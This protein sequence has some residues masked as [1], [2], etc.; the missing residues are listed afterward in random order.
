MFLEKKIFYAALFALLTP[1]V[2]LPTQSSIVLPDSA[3]YTWP[4]NNHLTGQYANF[5]LGTQEITIGL[6]SH[7]TT[8]Q[9]DPAW[10]RVFYFTTDTIEEFSF[11]I[12]TAPNQ[13]E[14]FFDNDSSPTSTLSFGAT[15]SPG[16]IIYL[17]IILSKTSII[18]RAYDLEGGA[19]AAADS[20]SATH[21]Q[22]APNIALLTS[23]QKLKV[24]SDS[25][26]VMYPAFISTSPV[27]THPQISNA[28]NLNWY[29][30]GDG[31]HTAVTGRVR[32]YRSRPDEVYAHTTSVSS[33]TGPL[34]CTYLDAGEP[35][36]QSNWAYDITAGHP[37]TSAAPGGWTYFIQKSDTQYGFYY[38]P[39][40]NIWQPIGWPEATGAAMHKESIPWTYDP[41]LMRWNQS[42]QLE[43]WTYDATTKKWTG[44]HHTFVT[45]EWLY[46]T[47]S[48]NY[49]TKE[50]SNETTGETWT[51]RNECAWHLD[52]SDGDYFTVSLA[53]GLSMK[54]LLDAVWYSPW[55]SGRM[56]GSPNESVYQ[57]GDMT[58]YY[59][60][61]VPTGS[62]PFGTMAPWNSDLTE[63]RSTNTTEWLPVSGSG[64][65]RFPR[66][67]PP[68]VVVQH[69]EIISAYDAGEAQE[70]FNTTPLPSA[71]WTNNGRSNEFGLSI[72]Y[73]TDEG[74]APLKVTTTDP[75]TQLLSNL[76][77]NPVFTSLGDWQLIDSTNG[78]TWSFEDETGIWTN[79]TTGHQIQY[80]SPS[81]LCWH[82]A[83]SNIS[84]EYDENTQTWS[85]VIEQS[86]S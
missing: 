38:D 69:Q 19:L 65:K 46:N 5:P 30:I 84:W 42:S 14:F 50:W 21:I 26:N 29:A 40:T 24:Q 68:L 32:V 20:T 18:L 7:V 81:A 49:E 78:H 16:D 60:W 73:D 74:T 1:C 36:S 22:D 39:A 34:S 17:H 59:N 55:R 41:V 75:N 66:N 70:I 31:T 62:R 44:A 33:L 12:A 6:F 3:W 48:Y 47:W 86:A 85:Q 8:A 37:A 13:V 23:W 11:K 76:L 61:K 28:N 72:P 4:G 25:V 83:T 43:N 53:N 57:N 80:S 51:N 71:T 77:Y 56:F 9:T 58:E 52:D 54:H 2:L 82:D 15:R 35:Q 63:W 79:S 27:T 64:S 10:F 45:N 67:F